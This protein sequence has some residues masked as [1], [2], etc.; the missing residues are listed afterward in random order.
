MKVFPL[1]VLGS[2]FWGMG[3][4]SGTPSE[5][6]PAPVAEVKSM[7]N[8][9]N[10]SAEQRQKLKVETLEVRL[11]GA[12][13]P[14]TVNGVAIPDHHG[15]GVVSAPISG[16]IVRLFAHEGDVVSNGQVVAE[17][18]SLEFAS[19]SAD[20]L[21][22]QT[23]ARF[24]K[25]EVERLK[26]LQSQNLAAQIEVQKAESEQSRAMAA[27]RAAET[28]LTATGIT[29]AYL[30]KWAN[31]QIKRP[32]LQVLAPVSGIINQHEISVGQSV[33]AYAQMMD[34]LPTD[35]VMVE[36]FLSPEQAEKVQAGDEAM[37]RM[38][39]QTEVLRMS[40]LRTQATMDA[41]RHAVRVLLESHSINGFPKPGQQ[42][43]VEFAALG[44]GSVIEVPLS[45]V[46][47]EGEDAYVFVQK[48]E[49]SFEKRAVKV[50]RLMGDAALISE[51]LQAG[52]RIATT[53]VFTLKALSRMNEFA[54]E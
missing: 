25:Q 49:A 8:L 28:K 5:A 10:L 14:T 53:E 45:A 2:L 37:V 39:G 30:A 20:F 7:P 41:E 32:T 16:R 12:G 15:M 27:L 1:F 24:R 18:E 17:L 34:I 36:A 23:E 52:E 29:Q 44:T 13:I 31:Q 19:L 54:E 48:A 4:G 21:Q 50:A 6:P 35:M 3:C 46:E 42:V 11:R 9:L 22:A 40:V 38:N 47:Y 26:A 51:G 33:A 43:Q